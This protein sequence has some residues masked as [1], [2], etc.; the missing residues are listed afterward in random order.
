MQA[1]DAA[2]EPMV[3]ESERAMVAFHAGDEPPAS[4]SQQVMEASGV[5]AEGSR[6]SEKRTIGKRPK[7]QKMNEQVCACND[8]LM[9]IFVYVTIFFFLRLPFFAIGRKIC[10]KQRNPK[11]YGHLVFS[12]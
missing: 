5:G 7:K 4:E 1:S 10:Y 3:P 2:V 9:L 6:L 11:N 12:N 8:C